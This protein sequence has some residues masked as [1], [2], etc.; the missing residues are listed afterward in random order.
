MKKLLP[1]SLMFFLSLNLLAQE[2]QRKPSWSPPLPEKRKML[3]PS[4]GLDN[5]LI[6]K[7]EIEME[8]ISFEPDPILTT[9]AENTAIDANKSIEIPV[10]TLEVEAPVDE[11]DTETI[12]TEQQ[13]QAI[14]RTNTDRTLETQPVESKPAVIADK[15]PAN[16]SDTPLMIA[17]NTP[18]QG[19]KTVIRSKRNTNQED[20]N[21]SWTVVKSLPLNT[22]KAYQSGKTTVQLYVTIDSNGRVVAVSP[23]SA[24]E[25]RMLAMHAS[26]SVQKW[27]FEAPK[28]YGI[29]E[30]MSR[31]LEI[32]MAP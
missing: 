26:R 14:D 19:E 20:S 11:P 18:I 22:P 27:R 2:Q 15:T 21:Y 5:Q 30:N 32:E 10:Q 1:I 25:N 3:K 17:N 8:T 7:E 23:A 16:V 6:K 29:D 9:P 28:K 12:L 13:P 4:V 24:N 31:T